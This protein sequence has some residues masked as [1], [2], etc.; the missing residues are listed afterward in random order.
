[1]AILE[2]QEVEDP[3]KCL[4]VSLEQ[5]QFSGYGKAVSP[6]LFA[7][8]LIVCTAN[9]TQGIRHCHQCRSPWLQWCHLRS[10]CHYTWCSIDTWMWH[11]LIIV[12]LLIKL[13][14]SNDLAPFCIKEDKNSQQTFM[15]DCG[16]EPD[17]NIDNSVRQ[18]P[19]VGPWPSGWWPLTWQGDICQ[20]RMNG[21]WKCAV[22]ILVGGP[23]YKS[24]SVGM[25]PH[26]PSLAFSMLLC[27]VCL[28]GCGG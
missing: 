3:I 8:R 6:F 13:L 23:K 25:A 24:D 1:M 18:L 9:H 5:E 27:L 16:T 15:Q 11:Q 4:M 21:V 20:S 2:T 14:R 7:R 28:L 12:L 26:C 17:E 10:L 22:D 19:L